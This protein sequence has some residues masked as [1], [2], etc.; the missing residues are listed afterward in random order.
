MPTPTGCK[1]SGSTSTPSKS[2]ELCVSQNSASCSRVRNRG[3]ALRPLPTVEP[4]LTIIH[5]PGRDSEPPLLPDT[6]KYR[7]VGTC[8]RPPVQP[9]APAGKAAHSPLRVTLGL[10][11]LQEPEL[12]TM[13]LFHMFCPVRSPYD[14]RRSY[15]LLAMLKGIASSRP[16]GLRHVSWHILPVPTQIRLVATEYAALLPSVRQAREKSPSLNR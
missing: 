16:C 4:P 5:Q 2:M 10:F 1:V 9:V 14:S 15:H 6:K 13:G 7:D 11:D 3:A 8:L 12:M